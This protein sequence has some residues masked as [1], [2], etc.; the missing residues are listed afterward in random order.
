[1]QYASFGRII[2]TRGALSRVQ[3]SLPGRVDHKVR[4]GWVF[5]CA[6]DPKEHA[7][8]GSLFG[9]FVLPKGTNGQFRA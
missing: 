4:L 3:V 1:M 8:K 2:I 9:A 5:F 7:Q 6:K